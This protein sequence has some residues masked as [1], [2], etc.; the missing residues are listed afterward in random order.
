MERRLIIFTDIGDTVI[1]EGT[2]VREVPF[3]EV[4]RADCVPGA[5]EAMLT[6][7]DKGYTI[8]MVAD[9]L[10]SS[11]HN[12][13]G[14]NGLNH[15]FSARA[16]SEELGQ[17]KPSLVMFQSALEQLGL[18][19][20]DKSRIIMVGNNLKRDILGAK[21]FGIR[22]VLLRW[23]PR[24]NIVPEGPEET[25]DYVIANPEELPALADRLD[26]LL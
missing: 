1:D 15:I 25:P 24:Y 2:E 11:F 4:L 14:Q 17:E 16:I 7:F 5:K 19:E 20:Q 26:A 13:M 21:R 22:S 12:T 3:G 9:G 23:S 18:S 10:T 6:L 8:A